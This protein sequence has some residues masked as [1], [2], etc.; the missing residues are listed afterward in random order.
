MISIQPKLP[1][2]YIKWN[3]PFWCGPTG[4]FGISFEGGSFWPVWSFLTRVQPTTPPPPA[5]NQPLRGNRTRGVC[6]S[7]SLI[8]YGNNFAEIIKNSFRLPNFPLLMHMFHVIPVR[9]IHR[10]IES[11]TFSKS[12]YSIPSKKNVLTS[13]WRKRSMILCKPSTGEG[14][15]WK[16]LVGVC[17]ILTLFQTKKCHFPH[18]FSDRETSKIQTRIKT[19]PHGKNYVII[20]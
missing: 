5:T 9:L 6:D 1:A 11:G 20:S 13:P 2:G 10:A 17:E 12:V 15:S 3:G 14:Y 8:V 4:I 18:P 16:F 19:W 7:S